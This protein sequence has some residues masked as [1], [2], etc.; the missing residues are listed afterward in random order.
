MSNFIPPNVIQTPDFA[1]LAKER[2]DRKRQEE[3]NKN[4]FLDQFEQ[5]QGLYLDGDR[6]AVQD[7]WNKVQS[8][9]DM[10]AEND[11]PESRR[12]LKQVYA[13]YAKVAGTA[14]VLAD[15]HRTQV[16]AYKADPTKYAMSGSDFFSWDEDFRTKT[17][18]FDDMQSALD[19]PNVL[20]SSASYALLN[21]YEQAQTLMGETARVAST[22]YDSSGVLDT[23]GL[24]SR[25]RDLAIKKI[26]ANPEAME[27][28]II[29]G[30]T[31]ANNPQ[32]G[33]AGDGDGKIN[34][35]E[36]LNMIKELPRE[37]R[38]KY[39][40][41]YLDALVDDYMELTPGNVNK[42]SDKKSLPT[43][44]LSIQ[45]A[46]GQ[47][48]GFITL[49][50]YINTSFDYEKTD[51]ISGETT[52]ASAQGK[53]TQIGSDPNG[54]LYVTIESTESTG[55][56][57]S[58]G[59]AITRTVVRHQPATQYQVDKILGK[60]GNS[61]DLS[62][63][64][65]PP[66]VEQAATET[67]ATTEETP[68]EATTTE[69]PDTTTQ[70]SAVTIDPKDDIMNIFPEAGTEEVPAQAT[71]KTE[72]GDKSFAYADLDDTGKK[73]V[74]KLKLK[75]QLERGGQFDRERAKSITFTK[76]ERNILSRWRTTDRLRN[77]RET[78]KDVPKNPYDIPLTRVKKSDNSII[79]QIIDGVSDRTS[80]KGST[81]KETVEEAPAEATEKTEEQPAK[82]TK[83]R[84]YIVMQNGVVV[85]RDEYD[86]K[87]AGKQSSTGTP[88]PDTFE[89]YAEMFQQTIKNEAEDPINIV[90]GKN[91]TRKGEEQEQI[92]TAKE[93]EINIEE[94]GL[95][96]DMPADDVSTE[97][98]VKDSEF[99]SGA[100]ENPTIYIERGGFIPNPD[101][102]KEGVPMPSREKVLP[103]TAK[104]FYTTKR[105]KKLDFEWTAE[106]V[107]LAIDRWNGNFA[108]QTG[109]DYQTII[110]VSNQFGIP[111]EL[112]IGLAA[113]ESELG[114]SNRP[115]KTKNLYNWGNT[116]KGDKRK[117]SEQDKK[118]TYF[119]TFE[120]GLY[121]WADGFVRLYRPDSGDWM[122]LFQE[123]APKFRID[124]D[125]NKIGIG[126]SFVV[127]RGNK[128]GSRYAANPEQEEA[129][130]NMIT[131]NIV[132]NLSRKDP[133][134][135]STRYIKKRLKI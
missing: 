38:Q 62:G 17:R 13:D 79:R 46:G 127:Q 58:E 83:N 134:K 71:E 87:F 99:R 16:A 131:W 23:L 18:S 3:T 116:T 103:K 86:S 8:T 130:R 44:P 43:T 60:Y 107:K 95:V 67:E 123:N 73:A 75:Q 104:S 94:E 61:Y 110:D 76:E 80:V 21:P 25:I 1:G 27:R 5:A 49:P 126:G 48:V 54:S 68:A 96:A 102:P 15:Q 135:K 118:N 90:A 63:L 97:G 47:E 78:F 9:I 4:A 65:P 112:I 52:T 121:A 6:P 42:Q 20:P 77:G 74:Q 19:N 2:I 111:V 93:E 39:M 69:A 12:Q 120:D 51:E 85:F 37:E 45:A 132:A 33:F 36:E 35:L 10:V 40:E 108:E 72:E 106:N 122:E 11:T 41:A 82:E 53:I 128:K 101:S 115:S 66:P 114:N 30:A 113:K 57:D 26:T 98:S 24:K 119:K 129:I 105:G 109:I 7:A 124:E 133:N 70:T 100:P 29:W 81:D 32:S 59:N 89:E 31:T 91:R 125:G 88:Y 55:E 64:T 56:V 117:G 84:D 34:S 14:Q 28:A 22:F 50:G 92:P